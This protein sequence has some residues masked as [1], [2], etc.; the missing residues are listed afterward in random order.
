[1]RRADATTHSPQAGGLSA[2]TRA[3]NSAACRFSLVLTTASRAD[4]TSRRASDITHHRL[5]SHLACPPLKHVT[6]QQRALKTS[7]KRRFWPWRCTLS[8]RRMRSSIHN[9]P[10]H[11][12]R[13]LASIISSLPGY[14]NLRFP[15]LVLF[16]IHTLHLI[17]TDSATLLANRNSGT[18]IRRCSA[19]LLA[20]E[21]SRGGS[22]EVP[23]RQA[24]R[25]YVRLVA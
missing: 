23:C 9:G 22:P 19:C 16:V 17:Y 5:V 7:R 1:M 13:A 14:L 20:R 18:V 24:E 6:Q 4:C 12:Q 2:R 25:E 15:H 21:S 3:S 11:K 10:P 8:P